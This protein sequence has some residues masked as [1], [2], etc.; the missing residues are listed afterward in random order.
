MMK[1]ITLFF[2]S[3][4]TAG[5]AMAQSISLTPGALTYTQDFNTLDTAFA[6][7]SS[8]PTGWSIF[9]YGTSAYANN[10]YRGNDGGSN[11]GD[12]YSYGDSASTERALGSVASGS[13][14]TSYGVQ[15][16]NN[17][18]DTII[19]FAVSYRCEQWRVGD[20]ASI[21]DTTLFMYS[22]AATGVSD[23]GNAWSYAPALNLNSIVL[24]GSGRI[25]GNANFSM[26]TDTVVVTVLPTRNITLKWKDINILGSDDGLAIDD[27]SITFITGTA[28]ID[29]TTAVR[30]VSG[31][32]GLTLKVLGKA[33]S[34][35]IMIQYASPLEGNYNLAIMDMTG[36]NVYATELS[37]TNTPQN[38]HVNGLHLAPGLYIGR[39]TNGATVTTVKFVIN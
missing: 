17:T 2:L 38:I 29:T 32:T 33:S 31:N 1:K 36:R 9:E 26:K 18:T 16:T 4:V 24:V 5:T 25:N 13:N 12:V 6:N 21:V 14:S 19:S 15:F 39:M 34:D 11:A 10:M 22:T 30:N 8:L 7:S 23:T 35:N 3:L 28:P 20:T 37:A 27:F